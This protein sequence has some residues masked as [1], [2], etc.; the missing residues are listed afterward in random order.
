MTLRLAELRSEDQVIDI[1]MLAQEHWKEAASI[2]L[3]FKPESI[4]KNCMLV[5]KDVDRSYRNVWIAY[6]D[7]K[8]IG[9]QVGTCLPYYFNDEVMGYSDIWYVLPEFRGTYAAI[10]LVKAF[11]E[12]CRLNGAL[13]I[14]NGVARTDEDAARHIRKLFPKMGYQW[15]GSYYIKETV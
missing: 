13:Q 7:E 10:K 11:E 3:P 4:I 9:Y 2:Q 15:A 1:T 12:W 14:I 6:K 8:P 5:L